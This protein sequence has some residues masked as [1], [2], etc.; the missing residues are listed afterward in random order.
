MLTVWAPFST[1]SCGRS[2]ATYTSPHEFLVEHNL[3]LRRSHFRQEGREGF[4]EIEEPYCSNE[5]QLDSH[6]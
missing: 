2:F 4:N 5:G 1:L 6:K 3:G